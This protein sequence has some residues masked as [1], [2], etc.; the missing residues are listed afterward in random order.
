MPERLKSYWELTLPA[1]HRPATSAPARADVLVVGAGFLGLWLAYFLSGRPRPPRVL[2]VERDTL[3]YGASSRNAG[4]MTCGGISEM[5]AD[6]GEAS[7]E[8]VLELFFR[9]KAGLQVILDEFPDLP[10]DPCGSADYDAVTD[11]KRLLADDIN[12]ALKARG[13]QPVFE[14]RELPFG[15]GVR[16]VMFNRFDR[17]VHP[18][19][20]LRA[21]HDRCLSRGVTFAH[22]V[23][24]TTVGEGRAALTLADGR[25]AE[26]AYGQG[27]LCVNGFSGALHPKTEIVPGRGQVLVTAPVPTA[28]A[29]TLGF[30]NAGFDYFR[31]VD[32]RLLVGGGRHLFMEHERTTDL[33]PSAEVLDY[34]R[35]LARGILGHDRFNIERHWAGI[36]GFKSGSHVSLAHQ[37][38]IDD[39]T[40]ELHACG[41]MGVALCPLA[42]REM[43]ASVS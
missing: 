21:L 4:F 25:P 3:G 5:L 40:T 7:R 35:L 6:M 16:R 8:Q 11:D 10:T 38:S 22:G 19:R 18:V 15:G 1:R 32:G 42:A 13:E 33:A 28:T 27:L 26:V 24:V 43:A 36:M 23:E 2:V 20:L 14:E 41:G 12:H 29:R 37:F 39:V 34:L 9:R 30:L 31:F 17:G